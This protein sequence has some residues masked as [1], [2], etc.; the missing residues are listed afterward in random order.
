M[1]ILSGRCSSN[2][3]VSLLSSISIECH[4]LY[5]GECDS[6][7][8]FM[9]LN[10][11]PM[12]KTC[13]QSHVET[14]CPL[15]PNGVDA[16]YPGD[17]NKMFE[18]II[19]DPSYEKYDITVVSRPDYAPGDSAETAGY[20]IGPWLL[21]FDNIVSADEAKRMVELGTARGYQRSAD[22]GSEQEDGTY[23]EFVNDGRTS[24]QSV[25]LLL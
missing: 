23:D 2:F 5:S 19:S 14:R 11:S 4:H 7:W 1:V 3:L 10:C 16:F 17:L 15:D 18:R 8:E 9:E 24:T 12:C 22:V 25:S 20:K 21:Q 6:N 13:E